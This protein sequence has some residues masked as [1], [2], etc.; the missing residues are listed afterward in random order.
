MV[1]VNDILTLKKYEPQLN[2]IRK[3]AKNFSKFYGLD[4]EE[5]TQE[6][7]KKSTELEK[8]GKLEE[9]LNLSLGITI[10][11]HLIDYIRKYRKDAL[12]GA[13]SLDLCELEKTIEVSPSTYIKNGTRDAQELLPENIKLIYNKGI[14][15]LNGISTLSTETFEPIVIDSIEFRKIVREGFKILKEFDKKV[16]IEILLW[17]APRKNIATKLRTN[18]NRIERAESR[19]WYV[20]NKLIIE[21]DYKDNIKDRDY[22]LKE[23]E[24]VHKAFKT[25][26]PQAYWPGR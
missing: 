10:K 1:T 5:L 23:L 6:C 19:I 21:S 17:S 4:E 12:Y 11:N 9:V 3:I 22:K 13:Y 2:Y 7:L 8:K 26:K 25:G 18:T 15:W 24:Y 20:L 14:R 16:L